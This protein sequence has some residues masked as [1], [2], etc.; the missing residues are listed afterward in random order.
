MF[1][2]EQ[3]DSGGMCR[4]AVSGEMTIYS[5]A[6]LKNRL[7]A[8]VAGS[9]VVECDLTEVTDFD[10][11][12]VQLLALLQRQ[13]GAGGSMS[14]TGASETVRELLDLYRLSGGLV[15]NAAESDA[16]R[17]GDAREAS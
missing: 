16:R 17:T 13:A 7:L 15:A 6:E 14:I 5:A 9:Q 4:I 8:A 2:L 12:G 10:S 1:T 11:A 3:Q